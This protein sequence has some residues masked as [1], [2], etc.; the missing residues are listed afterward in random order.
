MAVGIETDDQL[1]LMRG[2][3]IRIMQGYYYGK[4]LPAGDMEKKFLASL[5]VG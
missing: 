1:Q 5:V 3:G 4:P 2:L